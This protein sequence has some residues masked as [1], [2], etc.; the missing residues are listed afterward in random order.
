M[1]PRGRD[2]VN[3]TPGQGAQKPL[4]RRR[5]AQRGSLG[6]MKQVPRLIAVVAALFA[7]SAHEAG[8]VVVRVRRTGEI[9][10]EDIQVRNVAAVYGADEELAGRV[11]KAPIGL[12]GSSGERVVKLREV[13]LALLRA[14]FNLAE[15][16][17]RGADGCSVRRSAEEARAP[18]VVDSGALQRELTALACRFVAL[19]V[20]LSEREVDLRIL[21]TMGGLAA[22]RGEY[23]KYEFA[24]AVKLTRPGRTQLNLLVFDKGRY[25]KRLPIDVIYSFRTACVVAKRA[26]KAGELIGGADVEIRTVM[27]PSVDCGFY[28]SADNVIGKRVAGNLVAGEIILPRAVARAEI[29]RR[30]QIVTVV[31]KTPLV[32]LETYGRATS[33]GALGE[34]VSLEDTENRRKKFVGVVIGPNLVEVK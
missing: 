23:T 11:A 34:N 25:V 29:V 9:D 4:R 27:L 19:K 18:V 10:H 13:K 7:L 20:N 12:L 3:C 15:V 26:L 32:S 17:V 30:G 16:I 8:A 24:S 31:F 1:S 2:A 5:E 21:S 14:G 22:E 33:S 28:R 6:L